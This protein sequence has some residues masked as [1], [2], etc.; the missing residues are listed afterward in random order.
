MRLKH[1]LQSASA[2]APVVMVDDEPLDIDAAR[3]GLQKSG[4]E[5]AFLAFADGQ[6]FLDYMADVKAGAAEVPFIVL[7][8]V[9]M[10]RMTGMEVLVRL[11]SDPTFR[12]LPVVSM[13]TSSTHDQ[14]RESAGISGANDYL[15][16]P[17]DYNEYIRFFDS[18]RDDGAE[19]R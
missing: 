4:L 12:D 7:L 18:L 13:L 14:D 10:P 11:R 5:R 3:L 9:N 1:R 16:K 17:M 6:P 2:S 8:D 19:L 15:I